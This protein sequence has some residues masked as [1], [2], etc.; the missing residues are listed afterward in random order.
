MKKSIF[1]GSLIFLGFLFFHIW[2]FYRLKAEWKNFFDQLLKHEQTQAI[3]VVESAFASGGDPVEALLNFLESTNIIKGVKITIEGQKI[4]FSKKPPVKLFP[5]EEVEVGPLKLKF[6]YSPQ[7][8]L[9]YQRHLLWEFWLGTLISFVSLLALVIL[10]GLYHKQRLQFEKRQAEV[11]RIKSINLVITS[12]LHEVK[13]ALNTLKLIAYRLKKRGI[14]EAQ[15]LEKE[16]YRIEGY[17]KELSLGIK[18]KLNLSLVEIRELLEEVVRE[19]K[20][21]VEAKEIKLEMEV[22]QGRGKLDREKM[23]VVLRNLIKNACEAL[24]GKKE[25]KIKIKGKLIEKGFY[26]LLIMDSAGSLPEGKDLFRPFFTEKEGG[27]GIGLFVSKLIVEAHKG[28][29][30]AYKDKGYTIFKLQIPLFE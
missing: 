13:N 26:E 22:E 7:L 14:K 4:S 17:L 12:I 2:N 10:F 9:H 27:F 30:T 15:L 6:F 28:K 3:M 8:F 24:E 5:L 20:E 19:F 1:I 18:P 29:I 21:V 16:I 23:K 11:E 25:K